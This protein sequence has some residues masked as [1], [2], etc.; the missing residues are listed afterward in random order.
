[1]QIMLADPLIFLDFAR[2]SAL[3]QCDVKPILKYRFIV[4]LMK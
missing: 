3:A 4:R 1:M 2:I